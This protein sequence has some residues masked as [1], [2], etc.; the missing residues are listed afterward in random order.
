MPCFT[1]GN[2]ESHI[3]C[4]AAEALVLH[5]GQ[6][7][8]VEPKR[9]KFWIPIKKYPDVYVHFTIPVDPIE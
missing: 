8:N 3:A 7:M 5:Q 4:K 1:I 2:P 6:R 9:I